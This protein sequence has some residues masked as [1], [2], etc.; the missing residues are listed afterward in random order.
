MSGRLEMFRKP[1]AR[2]VQAYPERGG[3]AAK[4]I[5]GLTGVEAVPSDQAQDLALALV[6]SAKS[7]REGVAAMKLVDQLRRALA[8]ARLVLESIARTTPNC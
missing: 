6:K 1:A 5:G 8:R 4:N 3:G 2:S 7:A